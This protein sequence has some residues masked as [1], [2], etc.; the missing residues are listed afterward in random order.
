MKELEVQ[1]QD[2]LRESRQKAQA[3][4][5]T[6]NGSLEEHMAESTKQQEKYYELMTKVMA[7]KLAGIVQYPYSNQ[8]NTYH[9]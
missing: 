4:L 6:S 7:L 3:L 1:V 8:L 9:M 2:L 5:E